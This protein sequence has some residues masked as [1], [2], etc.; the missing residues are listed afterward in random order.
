M[1]RD[2]N[3]FTL[4][5]IVIFGLLLGRAGRM[6]DRY[7]TFVTAALRAAPRGTARRRGIGAEI[8]RH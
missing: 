4:A 7:E 1:V 6:T 5:E 2:A 3:R 8:R